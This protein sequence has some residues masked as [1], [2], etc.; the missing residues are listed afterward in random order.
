M[1]NR[2]LVV[3]GGALGDFVLTLPVWAA[4]R[5]RFP[6]ATLGALLPADRGQ[7]GEVAGV[8]DESRCLDDREW[9]SFFV[10]NGELKGPAVA[11]LGRFD[12][13]VSYLHDPK[14]VWET[15]VKRVWQ[16]DWL[17]GEGRPPRGGD[18]PMSLQLLAPLHR[19]GIVDSDPVPRVN[20]TEAQEIGWALGVHPG[21]GSETKNWALSRWEQFLQHWL[22]KTNNRLLLIGGE[23]ERERQAWMKSM[24]EDQGEVRFGE[25]LLKTAQA[26]RQCAQFVGHDS[27]VTHLAAALGVPCVVLWGETNRK[28]WQPQQDH[29]R[30]IDG[31]KGL[32]GISVKAVQAAVDTGG[33]R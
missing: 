12:A 8:F 11:W 20:F 25:S 17:Q 27:G 5:R 19:W 7:F 22:A 24:V 16:G 32:I 14:R 28:I 33:V 1:P 6:Q 26:L 3:R 18:C 10:E 13:I 9:A 23:A 15:N 4:L 2:I 29:V 31:G 21:S 30:V